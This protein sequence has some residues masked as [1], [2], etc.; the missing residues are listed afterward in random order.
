MTRK[1][2]LSLLFVS[3]FFVCTPFQAIHAGTTI[4]GNIVHGQQTQWHGFL[5]GFGVDSYSDVLQ[6]GQLV[7][8]IVFI[9]FSILGIIAV[10][11]MIYAGFLWLTAGGEENKAKQG[12]TLM[13]Q[14]VIGLIIILAAYT[15][16]YFV[17]YMLTTAISSPA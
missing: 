1:H 3:A 13:F 17:L 6:P 5:G 9:F 4:L 16:T 15:V 10:V 14:A 2:L 11:L 8:R 12:T 7:Q